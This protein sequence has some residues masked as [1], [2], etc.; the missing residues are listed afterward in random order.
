MGPEALSSADAKF[1]SLPQLNWSAVFQ[2]CHSFAL[3]DLAAESC[4]REVHCSLQLHQLLLAVGHKWPKSLFQGKQKCE[5]KENVSM[6]V[7]VRVPSPQLLGVLS[8]CVQRHL[9]VSEAPLS[10]WGLSDTIP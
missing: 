6:M 8:V 5:S 4:P 7:A 3:P 10:R 9:R 2:P 1:C